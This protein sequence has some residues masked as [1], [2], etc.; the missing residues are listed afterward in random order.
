MTI[1]RARDVPVVHLVNVLLT[2]EELGEDDT[3]ALTLVGEHRWAG[4]VTNRVN[5]FDRCLHALVDLYEAA[6]G[7]L[8]TK[9]LDADIIDDG[10]PACGDEHPF[11]LQVLLLSAN[12]DAHCDRA[13][14]NLHVADFGAG[15]D[16]DFP[17]LEAPREL[18][19]AIR[20]FQRKDARK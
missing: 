12:L 1:S 4:D 2:G 17:L 9:L 11:D 16:I 14:P 8:N 18:S 3:L 7:E 13:L 10:G 20:V 5:T 15:E 19:A 6:V